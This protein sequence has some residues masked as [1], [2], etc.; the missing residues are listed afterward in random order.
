MAISHVWA[1]GTG[2][3]AWQAGTV[4]ECLYGFFKNIARHFS[5]EGI[6]WD[7]LCIPREKAA[8]TLAIQKMEKSY[9]DAQITLVHDCFLRNWEWDVRTA[10]FAIIMSPWFS[11]GW[12]A[13]ELKK[14]Q[15]IKVIFKGPS[16]PVI[17]DLDEEILAQADE[18]DGP[19]KAGSQIIQNLR[20]EFSALKL[21][22]LL[23]VLR[24]RYT[25]WPKDMS[26][27]SALLAGVTAAGSQQ[28]TYRKVVRKFGSIAP[29]HLFHYRVTMSKGLTWCPTSLFDM[30]P[31]PGNASLKLSPDGSLVGR[32]RVL[33]ADQCADLEERCWWGNM[34]PL[35][36][37]EVQGALRRNWKCQLL[38]ECGKVH[39]TRALLVRETEVPNLYDYI[40]A[41][42]FRQEFSDVESLWVERNVTISGH[43]LQ[44]EQSSPQ[45]PDVS[46]V[47]RLTKPFDARKD[48]TRDS[49]SDT[50]LLHTAIWRRE[51]ETFLDLIQ[52]TDLSITDA[53][54]KGPLHLAA[55]RGHPRMVQ[56]LAF[57]VELNS[58][59]FKG[60]T[61][62]HS[63][64]W[65]GSTTVVATL[66]QTA[67]DRTIRDKDGNLA[68]HIAARF[69]HLEV[70]KL[71]LEDD[72]DI[73]GHN[74][75][76]PM[77]FATIYGHA[78]IVRLLNSADL[79][80]R[81][82]KFGW[83]PLHSAVDSGNIEIVKILI[84]RGADVN[85]MDHQAW[86]T[87]LHIAMING[88]TEVTRIL[89]ENGASMSCDKCGWMP[90][91]FAEANGHTDV[92][93]LLRTVSSHLSSARN[94]K[95]MPLHCRDLN[96]QPG[97][98]RL[99]AED[100][101]DI[102]VQ[103][104][105]EDWSEMGF[106]AKYNL[107]A[108]IQFLLRR[109][110]HSNPK[111]RIRLLHDSSQH[112]YEVL[113]RY[114][115]NEGIDV[116]SRSPNDLTP[117]HL[118]CQG[119]HETIV[120]ILLDARADPNA[121]HEASNQ[122]PLHI[123]A[124]DGH[125]GIVE[126][127]LEAGA[128]KDA[129]GFGGVTSIH[130]ATVAAREDCV[131]LLLKAD[132]NL[133]ISGTPMAS[134][135]RAQTPLYTA[136]RLGHDAIAMLLIEAMADIESPIQ[137]FPTMLH[138]AVALKSVPI[139][140]YLLQAGAD[141]NSAK[142]SRFGG[143]KP[144]HIAAV[145]GNEAIMQLLLDA[146][147]DIMGTGKVGKT[148]LHS[149]CERSFLGEAIPF[150]LNAGVEI[151]AQDELGRT[152]LHMFCHRSSP[153]K[154]GTKEGTLRK[155]LEAGP[156]LEIKDKA[157]KT[158]L[159]YAVA[160]IDTI[161]DLLIDAGA[162][163][164]AKGPM[165]QTPLFMARLGPAES[166]LSSGADV[167]AKDTRGQTPIIYA[168]MR[169]D[170]G[171][172]FTMVGYGASITAKDKKG[173]GYES[174]VDD[175][176][177]ANPVAWDILRHASPRTRVPRFFRRRRDKSDY[178]LADALRAVE[179]PVE[180]VVDSAVDED[181][182][183]YSIGVDGDPVQSYHDVLQRAKPDY[184]IDDVAD[185]QSDNPT[186]YGSG[187]EAR[188]RPDLDDLE[189]GPGDVLDYDTDDSYS[190]VLDY[191]GDSDDAGRGKRILR[192]FK[193]GRSSTKFEDDHFDGLEDD[194]NDGDDGAGNGDLESEG[195]YDNTRRQGAEKKNRFSRLFKRG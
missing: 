32:W 6:W 116:E 195:S 41:L 127:L 58:Q 81:D 112:G 179:A 173:K 91:F 162:N 168:S 128:E 43:R 74:D 86:W 95:W 194:H 49:T 34:H 40:G 193:L 186:D 123:A 190:D 159:H 172:M 1:D 126:L 59:C 169:G 111:D 156:D 132:V 70:F 184:H 145:S 114:L 2:T 97:L 20:K 71:L 17:K 133:E 11:R 45:N 47:R 185:Y 78:E 50:H 101:V 151:N 125:V 55:E 155:L 166:L 109:E 124:L 53:L 4:N 63:G 130:L 149:L 54:G 24:S 104:I 7:T 99:L 167:E 44:D 107:N 39:T 61:A 187:D 92:L 164:E 89:F 36:K 106:A 135:G 165:N 64:A 189:D 51:Y 147:A 119:G 142:K 87:P 90:N 181:H 121:Q 23:T 175:D 192:F 182:N 18:P 38:A 110:D 33:P 13:L 94:L 108:T 170:A 46:L 152:A 8:R 66:L 171:A 88:H 163:I 103:S 22:D 120:R 157:E 154:L 161:T 146:G 178:S 28:E 52:R 15:K 102:Y 129:T 134:K 68:L 37:P 16:G 93:N 158:A 5:C 105:T 42:S 14:S 115:L 73:K 9:E 84:Q 96:R 141:P 3:G 176:D 100:G 72:V 136:V 29:G 21:D 148:A 160:N 113:M 177:G 98:S 188:H 150:L 83:T 65:G 131:R 79:E 76:T 118:A 183:S 85:A 69:G 27:I 48:F 117:L 80:A 26:V 60:Q 19:R 140:K 122:R 153:S 144:L 174:Y 12:T 139:T 30:P 191:G 77:H 62:L 31:D 75:L 137:N 56:D 180:P 138:L 143:S 67:I 35:I 57:R 10:C 82:D 25:S